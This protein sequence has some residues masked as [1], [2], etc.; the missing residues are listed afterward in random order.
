MEAGQSA[1]R[2]LKCTT[3]AALSSLLILDRRV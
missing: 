2:G 1:V 3:V